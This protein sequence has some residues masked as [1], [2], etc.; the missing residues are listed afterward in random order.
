[1][2]LSDIIA[3]F[4]NEI[5]EEEGSAELR[6][7]DMAKR[8]SCVPSQINYV[9]S[10]RFTPELGYLVQSRRGEGGY[11][12]ITRAEGEGSAY[13]MHIVGAIGSSIDAGS[14]LA[15]LQNMVSRGL[16]DR[17]LARVMVSAT[18]EQSCGRGQSADEL[19]AVLLKNMLVALATD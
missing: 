10:S 7:A 13:L 1:M 3:D 5:L 14:C 4:I 17:L 8:F 9:I 15:I 6:R 2:K 12:R 11:I 18:S 16:I 19:R